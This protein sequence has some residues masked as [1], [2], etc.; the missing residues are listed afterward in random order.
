MGLS[1]RAVLTI[2]FG[3]LV[4]ALALWWLAPDISRRAVDLGRRL[5]RSVGARRGAG[6]PALTTR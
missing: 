6:S 3:L 1:G 4:D 2:A 5:V